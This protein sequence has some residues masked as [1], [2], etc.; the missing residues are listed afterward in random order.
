MSAKREVHLVCSSSRGSREHWGLYFPSILAKDKG[1]IIHVVGAPLLGFK[2]EV[3][4]YWDKT[5]T[6]GKYTFHL[7]GE[8][9]AANVVDAKIDPSHIALHVTSALNKADKFEDRAGRIQEPGIAPEHLRPKG[10]VKQVV[11][12]WAQDIPG[13]KRCQEWTTE[14]IHDLVKQGLLPETALAVRNAVEAARN[15]PEVPSA[16]TPTTS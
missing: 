9:D 3:K 16:P 14:L 2:H 7:L 15:V 1:K 12:G 6:R 4:H 13:V 10:T 11:A 8:T 5:K